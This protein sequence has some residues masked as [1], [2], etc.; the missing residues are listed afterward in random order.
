MGERLVKE[1]A[2]EAFLIF[3]PLLCKDNK[4]KMKVDISVLGDSRLNYND[5]SM[6]LLV[7]IS[8]DDE[9]TPMGEFVHFLTQV[10]CNNFIHVF[11]GN[12]IN[13]TNQSL[14]VFPYFVFAE[15]ANHTGNFEIGLSPV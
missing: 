7:S 14:H 4:I 3:L 13:I 9:S 10:P 12:L 1:D 5:I 2:P 11:D 15:K 6:S 8:V